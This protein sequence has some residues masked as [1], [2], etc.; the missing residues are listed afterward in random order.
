MSRIVEMMMCA[1]ICD[2]IHRTR[3]SSRVGIKTGGKAGN[4]IGKAGGRQEEA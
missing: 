2:L 3:T 4:L 1:H